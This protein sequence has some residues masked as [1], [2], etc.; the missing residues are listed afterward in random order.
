MES[1]RGIGGDG[2]IRA[3]WSTSCEGVHVLVASKAGALAGATGWPR[4]V[5][6]GAKVGVAFFR[7][8]LRLR[9]QPR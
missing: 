5:T 2:H 7:K 8:G 6:V 1:G 4:R 9:R 3:G